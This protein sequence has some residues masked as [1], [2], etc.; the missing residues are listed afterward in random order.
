MIIFWIS[1][2]PNITRPQ[3]FFYMNKFSYKFVSHFRI[4]TT[5]FV[6]QIEKYIKIFPKYYVLIMQVSNIAQKIIKSLQSIQLFRLLISVGHLEISASAFEY[7]YSFLHSINSLL[8]QKL[9]LFILSNTLLPIK[10]QPIDWKPA[11]L[12]ENVLQRYLAE[13]P[14]II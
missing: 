2:S 8:S 12:S 1:D 11:T 14:P 7:K 6:C 13:N 5:R 9:V 10:S 3:T 4:S